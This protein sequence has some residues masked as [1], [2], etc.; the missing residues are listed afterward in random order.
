MLS[1]KTVLQRGIDVL[2]VRS[3]S[4]RGGRGGLAY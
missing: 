1:I 3:H 2:V 4:N